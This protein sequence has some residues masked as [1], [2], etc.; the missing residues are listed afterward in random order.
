MPR[1]GLS[2]L[3]KDN[4]GVAYN[5]EVMCNKRTGEFLIKTADGDA[6]SFQ[7]F[8]RLR[9]HEHKTENNA[10]DYGFITRDG[11][12]CDIYNITVDYAD[13]ENIGTMI[14][15]D[16]V[17]L[18]T[19]FIITPV[20]MPALTHRMLIS[21]DLDPIVVESGKVS[22]DFVTSIRANVKFEIFDSTSTSVFSIDLTESPLDTLSSVLLTVP[23]EYRTDEYTLK[24]TNLSLNRDE[25]DTNAIRLVLHSIMIAIESIK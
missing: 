1:L 5:E 17:S 6:M 20:D 25:S 24:L 10:R 21:I 23:D 22:H 19:N 16:V 18:D 9:N 8:S 14:L 4:V 3:S 12:E 11:Y 7:Y 15:P 2:V 13:G